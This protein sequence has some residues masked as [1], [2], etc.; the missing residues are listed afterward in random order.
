MYSLYFVWQALSDKEHE[1]QRYKTA[2]GEA[3]SQYEQAKK[4]LIETKENE[5][6][7][8]DLVREQIS[9]DLEKIIS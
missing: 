7:E 9:Y 4:E 5:V 8:W 6:S 2:L 3:K 1:L